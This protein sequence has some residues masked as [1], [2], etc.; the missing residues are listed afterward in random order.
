MNP[1]KTLF[2]SLLLLNTNCFSQDKGDATVTNVTKITF[3]NPGASYEKSIAK[4]QTIYI[5]AFMNTS[6]TIEFSDYGGNTSTFYFDPAFTIQYRYYYS[7][8]RR[9]RKGARTDMNSANYLAAIYQDVFSKRRIAVSYYDEDKRRALNTVG[10]AWG[11]QRNYKRRF[12][13]DLNLGV[14]YL[15]A[16][17]TL[18]YSSSGAYKEHSGT[19]T[20]PGQLNLGI[21][22]NKKV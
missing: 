9:D 18:A 11:M 8:K 19:F 20:F 2:I 14:G 10:V 4:R 21:W 13:F 15:F 3:I 6:G 12:S 17:S 5:Q 22:L 1:A 7:L 16:K